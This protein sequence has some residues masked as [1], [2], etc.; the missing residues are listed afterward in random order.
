MTDKSGEKPKEDYLD[1]CGGIKP[2]PLVKERKST[3]KS[4]EKN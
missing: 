1:D 4:E 2:I 3:A